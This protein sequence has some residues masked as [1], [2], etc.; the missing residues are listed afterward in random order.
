MIVVGMLVSALIKVV[1]PI[2]LVRGAWWLLSDFVLEHVGIP[3][4]D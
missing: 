1:V 2:A 3:V 4:L